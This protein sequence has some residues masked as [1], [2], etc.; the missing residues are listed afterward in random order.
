MGYTVKTK[1]HLRERLLRSPLSLPLSLSKCLISSFRWF[2]SVVLSFIVLIQTFSSTFTFFFFFYFLCKII[3]T[4]CALWCGCIS[5]RVRTHQWP[6]DAFNRTQFDRVTSCWEHFHFLL[7]LSLSHI[8]RVFSFNCATH[9]ERYRYSCKW[10]FTANLFNV[11]T[12]CSFQ[13]VELTTSHH[14][15]HPFDASI[16]FTGSTCFI[17]IDTEPLHDGGG[18]RERR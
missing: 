1:N 12:E 9:Q 7:S 5:N 3:C 17:I 4:Q 16:V 13:C 11:Y 2:V 18:I 10:K 14:V 15:T 8:I 6:S